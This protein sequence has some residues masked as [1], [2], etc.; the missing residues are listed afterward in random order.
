MGLLIYMRGDE[1]E[2]SSIDMGKVTSGIF[3]KGVLI[4][5]KIIVRR[6]K[7]FKGAFWAMKAFVDGNEVSEPLKNNSS[8]DI[9]VP[10]GRHSLYIINKLGK[11]SDIIEF[12]LGEDMKAYFECGPKSIFTLFDPRIGIKLELKEIMEV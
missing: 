11:T 10:S 1:L 6:R 5:S 4:M 7:S 3:Y 2:R 8:I 9:Q 12:D